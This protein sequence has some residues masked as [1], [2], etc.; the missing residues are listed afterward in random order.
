MTQ[1]NRD[2]YIAWRKEAWKAIHA[3]RKFSFIPTDRRVSLAQVIEKLR[4]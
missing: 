2:A 1:M 4:G 3:G